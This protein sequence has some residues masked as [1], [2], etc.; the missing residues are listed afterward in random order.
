MLPYGWLEPVSQEEPGSYSPPLETAQNGTNSV[1][2]E[3]ITQGGFLHT[4]VVLDGANIGGTVHVK[5]EI[6]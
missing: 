4:L 6:I 1:E 3:I 2:V 5:V